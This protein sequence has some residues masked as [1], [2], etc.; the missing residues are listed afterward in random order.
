M[1]LDSF[2][3]LLPILTLLVVS[4]WRGVRP[5]VFSGFALTV[6]LFF[7][8]DGQIPAMGA[9]IATAA[10]QTVNILMIIF[11]ALF[12]YQ[13]MEDHGFIDRIK[14][15]FLQIHPDRHV[16]LFFWPSS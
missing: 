2:L 10:V 8:L 6:L 13:I 4:L 9:S 16:R 12:L 14:E 15:T 11:G 5:A 3:A 1:N 7:V